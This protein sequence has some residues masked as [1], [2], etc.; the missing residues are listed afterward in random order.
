MGS[1]FEIFWLNYWSQSRAEYNR[2]SP[3]IKKKNRLRTHPAISFAGRT[4][5]GSDD[6]VLILTLPTMSE[7]PQFVLPELIHKKDQKVTQLLT[8]HNKHF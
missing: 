3:R 2:S 8:S 7:P 5:N 1:S 6:D 4:L